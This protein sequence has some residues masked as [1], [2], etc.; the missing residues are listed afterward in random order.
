MFSSK[1]DT[2]AFAFK[3][4]DPTTGGPYSAPVDILVD[5]HQDRVDQGELGMP[6]GEKLPLL[7]FTIPAESQGVGMI[8]VTP[9]FNSD[10]WFVFD[11]WPIA[12]TNGG[13]AITEVLGG[14][15]VSLGTAMVVQGRVSASSG[16]G[17]TGSQI[18]A[19]RGQLYCNT[20]LGP[21]DAELKLDG[22]PGF[23]SGGCAG[24]V[25]YVCVFAQSSQGSPGC[26]A[27]PTSAGQACPN[28][29]SIPRCTN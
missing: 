1:S 16:N 5:A 10:V 11:L 24:S 28:A 27:D 15:T 8:G 25:G 18:C 12:A 29:V 2:Q 19:G 14:A 13:D 23:C 26:F 3:L 21:Q 4:Q 20:Y 17:M 22:I 7:A 9:G 6:S